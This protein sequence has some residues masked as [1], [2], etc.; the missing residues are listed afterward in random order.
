MSSF[1][2]YSFEL[3]ALN[4]DIASLLKHFPS[5]DSPKDIGGSIFM[6]LLCDWTEEGD[7]KLLLSQIVSMYLQMFEVELSK[8][9]SMKESIKNITMALNIVRTDALRASSEKLQK[10]VDLQRLKMSDTRI[11]HRA[12]KDLF[13]V[14]QELRKMDSKTPSTICIRKKR[15]KERRRRGN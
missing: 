2:S 14:F 3:S 12:I 10:L 7:R 6:P 4:K 9:S 11:Q 1:G 13:L 15:S 5:S 8:N